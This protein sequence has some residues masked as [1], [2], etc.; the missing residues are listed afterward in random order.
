M[1]DPQRRFVTRAGEKLDA[2][3]RAFA[4]N[5]QD[6]ICADLGCH[7]GGFTDCLLQH[8]ALRVHAVD[9]GFGV[10]DYRLRRDPRVCV[11]ERQNALT[12]PPVEPCSL[13]TID[14]GWTPQRL[15]LPAAARWIGPAGGEVISLIKP[16]YE[17]DAA[18]LRG[19]VLPDEAH[20]ALLARLRNEIERIG[21]RILGELESPIAGH[22]GNREWLWRLGRA[23]WDA[24]G[25]AN[26]MAQ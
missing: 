10:L 13:V 4:I 17:A 3:L 15:I 11:H 8:G 20:A 6:R 14:V 2:A 19:G 25:G 1:A 24:G 26:T 12:L 22:S 5:A 16:H 9:P 18:A 7:A 23:E 21:W